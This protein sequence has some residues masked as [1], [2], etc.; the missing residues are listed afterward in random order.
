MRR[1]LNA[2][3]FRQVLDHFRVDIQLLDVTNISNSIHGA[4]I[5]HQSGDGEKPRAQ[6]LLNAALS[7]ADRQK[8]LERELKT[9]VEH[10]LPLAF[11]TGSPTEQI[12]QSPNSAPLSL[13]GIVIAEKKGAEGVL[14]KS[15]S[16]VWGAIVE[17][18]SSDWSLAYE[19]PPEKWEEIV[20]GAYE[21]A[22]FEVI[23]TPRSGDHGRDVIAIRKGI[24]SIK[25]IGS[26]KAYKPG[27]LVPYDHI[28]SLLGV[29]A[30]ERDTSKGIITTTSDF[31]PKILDDP[32]IAPFLPYRLELMNGP[33][34][35]KWLVSLLK[36]EK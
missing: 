8:A 33:Q 3:I 23:L 9:L 6:I 17:R 14:I 13:S 30:G 27:N 22:G 19:I 35:Q 36:K 4:S 29:M 12:D 2:E 15:T 20:A 21:Q 34:L 31:P 25:I 28:R 18:L 1:K 32:F 16:L 10:Q 11:P 7:P 5:V 24:G 26:V